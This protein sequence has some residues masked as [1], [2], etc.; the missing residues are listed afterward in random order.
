LI[1]ILLILFTGE[2]WASIGRYPIQNFTPSDY[3]AGIQN[4]DFA[5]NRDMQ[6]FVANNLGVLSYNG[7]DWEVHAYK[8]GKKQRSLAFDES[9]NRLYVGTQGDFGYFEHDWSY[10]SLVDLIPADARNF[11]EVWDVFIVRDKVYFCTFQ[12]IYVYDLESISAIHHQ[13]GF[14]RSFVV[15]GNLFTQNKQ[16]QLF[17][18]KDLTLEPVLQ[19]SQ[20]NQVVAGIIPKGSGYLLFYNSGNIEFSSSLNAASAYD[21]LSK[22]LQGTYVNH[23]LQLSDSRLVVST[24]TAGLF[25]C[26]LTS[27]SWERINIADGLQTNACLRSFQDYAGNLWV[28]LQ[29]GISLV[30]IN[31]PMRLVNEEIQLQ[32][33]GYEAL[34]VDNGTYFTTS[35]GIYYYS[36]VDE[37]TTFLPGTEGPAYGLQLVAGSVYAGHHNGLYLL[38]ERKAEL[39]TETHGLWQVRHLQSNPDFAIGGTYSGLH[40][41]TFDEHQH[42]RSLGKV[43][44]FNESS[45]FMEEDNE[46]N[47]IVSQ[48]YKGLFKLELLDNLTDVKVSRLSDSLGVASHDQIILGKIDNDLYIATNQGLFQLDGTNGAIIDIPN[49]SDVIGTQPVYLLKQDIQKNIHIIAENL[50]GFFKQISPNNYT[51]VPSSLFQL[52]YDLNTDLLNA[53]INMGQGIMYSANQGFIYYDPDK[54]DRIGLERPLILKRLF[55]VT[56]GKDLY[57]QWP[58]AEKPLNT[59]DI[60]VNQGAKKLQF[61]VESFQFRNKNNQQYR[62]FLKGFDEEFGSWIDATTK[63]YT[64]L[65]GGDYTFIAQTRNYLGGIT[66]SIPLDLIVR[67]PFYQ[68]TFAKV[69]Y[70]LMA[71]LVLIFGYRLPRKRFERRELKLVEENR[72]E[73]EAKQQRLTEI[74]QQKDQEL[75]QMEEEKHATELEHLNN[76]L[77][78]STMNLVVKNEFIETIKEEL[79][80]IRRKGKFLETKQAL[81]RIEREID[82]NLRLQEDWEQFEH[83]FDKVH[84]DFLS[85]LRDE[86]GD[87]TPNEQ[88]L[89]AFL[90]LNLNT[91]EIANLM[92]ISLRG[93]EI[94]RY[95]LRMKLGLQKGQN[96]SKFILEY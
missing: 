14:D 81:E 31:S 96:L 44:G 56:Q 58:F 18:I 34:Q 21:L 20:T 49:L 7:S 95:R 35:N 63:E 74:E 91:K 85:R 42:L 12:Q 29:S 1:A 59:G 84:G 93:V 51:F 72:N 46:G 71:C 8:T 28:G 67:P 50:V 66:E 13:G 41:F 10:V 82:R 76:L 79:K 64:N 26:D 75:M 33:S 86:F 87:L 68:S 11:D 78:A 36:N 4:I 61:H 90:R 16:G 69:V 80:E 89:C 62:Y 23:V 39:I 37:K 92:S 22:A 70:L 19:Q 83:H 65:K 24:Q 55:N 9:H 3:R 30:H 53:S 2:L 88:K 38:K 45:R 6:L 47:I 52:R 57:V 48:Y 43:N 54:E 25:L 77:A 73:L 5:Q 27:G 94:A 15:S 32:G 40:L 17:E 60:V